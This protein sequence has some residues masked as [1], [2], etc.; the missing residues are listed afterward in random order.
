MH[1]LQKSFAFSLFLQI[2]VIFNVHGGRD[3]TPA[4]SD[5]VERRINNIE[6]SAGDSRF[7][8]G[9]VMKNGFTALLISDPDT[10]ISAASLSVAVGK[11]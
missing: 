1:C 4:T 8:R 10:D 7:Y 6:K 11:F 9:L 3:E 2:T 5:K